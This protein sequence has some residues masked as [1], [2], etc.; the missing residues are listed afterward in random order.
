MSERDDV[1]IRPGAGLARPFVHEL[2]GVRPTEPA[3]RQL[4]PDGRHGLSVD[5]TTG[6]AWL[7]PAVLTPVRMTLTPGAPHVGARLALGAVRGLFDLDPDWGA[8]R[9]PLT[10][11]VPEFADVVDALRADPSAALATLERW[12]TARAARAPRPAPSI[13]AAAHLLTRPHPPNRVRDIADA[14]GC[15]VRQLQRRFRA[16]VGLTPKQ[17]VQ[18]HRARLARAHIAAHPERGLADVAAELGFADQ[19]QMTRLF[20][21]YCGTTPGRYRRRKLGERG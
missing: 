2:W 9:I 12:L 4:Y 21:R 1:Q 10:D 17:I 6:D 5:L 15:T 16:E 8:V 3:A 7:E 13:A 20:A 14:V 18:L 19:A 11:L